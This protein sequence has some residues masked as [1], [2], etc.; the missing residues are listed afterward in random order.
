MVNHGDKLKP[1]FG[2]SQDRIQILYGRPVVEMW[3]T[4]YIEEASGSAKPSGHSAY[5]V[6][7]AIRTTE[8]G[9]QNNPQRRM[10]VDLILCET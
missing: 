4:A 10:L 7:H 6:P 8:A 3:V 5:G 1:S 9:T 2:E